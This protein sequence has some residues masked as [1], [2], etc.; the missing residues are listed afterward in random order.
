MKFR[1]LILLG[2]LVLLF[3]CKT[4]T[5]VPEEKGSVVHIVAGAFN[6]QTISV[7]KGE[8]VCWVN[9]DAEDAH[10]PA[11]NDHPTHLLYPG[12]DPGHPV[13]SG[14]RWCFTFERV[15]DAPYHDHFFPEIHGTVRVEP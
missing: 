13:R 4:A 12:F 5:P 6:P 3:G 7:R 15:G 9:D 1:P 10:W 8:A 14:D 2:I 11:S